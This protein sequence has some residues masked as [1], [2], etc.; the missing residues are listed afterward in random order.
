MKRSK[1]PICGYL[2]NRGG[3]VRNRGID[4]GSDTE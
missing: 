3:R 4:F 2:K 1:E